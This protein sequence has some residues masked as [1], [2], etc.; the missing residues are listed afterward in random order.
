MGEGQPAEPTTSFRVDPA[1]TNDELNALFVAAW[2]GFD[3][4]DFGPVL[5]R[6]LAYV[7]AYQSARLCGFVNLAWDG[8]VHAFLLDTTVHPDMRR[9]GVGRRLVATAVAE[10]A[11]RGMEWVHVD[12]EPPLRDFYA[13]CGFQPTEA[14]LIDLSR[15]MPSAS[16]VDRPTLAQE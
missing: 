15:H 14:G 9:R 10:A 8:G 4:R 1:V 16:A 6:S 12:F 5:Q 13:A 3:R 11:A 2:P 7:G